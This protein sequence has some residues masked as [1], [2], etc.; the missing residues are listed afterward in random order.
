MQVR[1]YKFALQTRLFLPVR[2]Q[3]VIPWK[4]PSRVCG[5]L[6]NRGGRERAPPILGR[7][8]GV[9]HA[10]EEGV[11]AGATHFGGPA[12]ALHVVACPADD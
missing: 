12:A 4:V 9:L 11:R 5:G 3:V 10:E 2:G 1:I 6:V 8:R 7:V